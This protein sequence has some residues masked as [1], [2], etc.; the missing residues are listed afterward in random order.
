MSRGMILEIDHMSVKAA[1]RALDI[2][3]SAFYP[4]V[5][6]SHSWMDKTY[7]DR[8]YALGGFVSS[9]G[10]STDEYIAEWQSAQD[11]RAEYD[12]GWG[13]GMD[14]NGFG[15]TPAPPTSAGITYPFRADGGSVLD[16]GHY[17][18]SHQRG[19]AAHGRSPIR[20][21]IRPSAGNKHR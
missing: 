16:P 6:S 19:C 10:H 5:V 12:K 20:S 4:G 3:E 11:Q 21:R 7:I 9:S 2:L 15:G 1:D 14:M 17:T 18:R 13:Y 8:L